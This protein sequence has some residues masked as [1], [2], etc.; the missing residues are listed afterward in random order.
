MLDVSVA[1]VVSGG[2][3]LPP[4]ALVEDGTQW[5]AVLGKSE[6]FV[7]GTG[8]KFTKKLIKSPFALTTSVSGKSLLDSG[9]LK[10]GSCFIVGNLK[11]L[12]LGIKYI[13]GGW[14]NLDEKQ[15]D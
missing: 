6:Y 5:D 7:G 10:I 9:H 3:L 4:G 13:V 12:C 1:A 15:G 2:A 14:S 8:R 11:R